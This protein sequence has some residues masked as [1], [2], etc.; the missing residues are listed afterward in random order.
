MRPALVG[1]V[2]LLAVLSLTFITSEPA[3]ASPSG[4]GVSAEQR[5]RVGPVG[6]AGEE[7]G[8]G[9][10]LPES[11]PSSTD[12][13]EAH[14]VR[15][16]ASAPTTS[17]DNSYYLLESNG[18]LHQ[19]GS[20]SF[21]GSLA[22]ERLGAP[23]VAGAPTADG[24][25]YWL[26]TAN[27]SVRNLGDA[28]FF[29]SAVHLHLAEPVTAFAA[30]PDGKGYWLVTANGSVH[31]YGDARFFG[32]PIHERLPAAV[33]GFATTTDGEGYW[34]VTAKGNL[35]QYGDAHF[36]GSP[37]EHHIRTSTVVSI[38]PTPSDAGYWISTSRGSVYPYGDAVFYRSAV[39]RKLAEPVVSLTATPDGKGYW[40]ATASGA[41]FAYGDAASSGSLAHA[42][43]RTD[44]VVS[45]VRSTLAEVLPPPPPTT[46]AT[47]TATTSPLTAS[48]FAHGSFGYDISDYQCSGS[49]A[50]TSLPPTSGN[51]A[52]EV[53][54]WLD[55]ADNPCLAA[56]ATWA[57]NAHTGQQGSAYSLYLFMNSPDTS[58]A[59]G[60]ED[61]TGPDGTCS[62]LSGTNQ[63][64][65]LAYNYGY[66]GAKDAF[67]YA[68]AVGV[69]SSLWWL[70]VEDDNL[71]STSF[72]SFPS[73]YWSGSTGLND[74]TIQ[75]AFDALRQSGVTVGI[76]S[77]SVQW[78]GIAGSYVPA[79]PQVPLWVAGAPWTNPPYTESG[80]PNQSALSTWCAGTATYGGTTD[81]AAFAGGV[82]WL[83]QETPGNEA[84]P[85]GLDPDYAC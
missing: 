44:K 10:A 81:T 41:I 59:A 5:L 40:L 69:T 67:A 9:P 3:S 66:N 82:P 27:G 18:V 25:G 45:L 7:H 19:Y 23:I 55:S 72:S 17:A 35:Y 68:S 76:Y 8:P 46:T 14:L 60:T 42:S 56:E 52:L 74:L 73:C 54:G 78:P 31:N 36:V 83:L 62:S 13:L 29:G 22:H 38:A 64:D 21:F 15:D 63:L 71:C 85:Y 75:G 79:G 50:S 1:A 84:S 11:R 57:T 30:T 58:T 70:D 37:V 77:T 65:C 49:T 24:K 20:A 80:L 33:S 28:G 34:I 26:V 51:S 48:P 32:S 12:G 39:H 16:A 2:S 47:D 43:P 4:V 61:A 53:A 6:A